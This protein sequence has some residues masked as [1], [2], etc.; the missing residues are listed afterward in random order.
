MQRSVNPVR[1]SGLTLK[2]LARGVE[3]KEYATVAMAI[4]RYTACLPDNAVEQQRLKSALRMLKVK[5]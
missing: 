1:V 3:M 2:E 5:V 4:K